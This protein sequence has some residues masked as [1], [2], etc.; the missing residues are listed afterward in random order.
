MRSNL[1]NL[2]DKRLGLSPSNLQTFVTK[3]D[4]IDEGLWQVSPERWYPITG[5][6]PC[7]LPEAVRPD[8]TA[9]FKRHG[10]HAA[11]QKGTATGAAREQALTTVTFSDKWSRFRNYGLDPDHK[12]FL[13]D[14]YCKKLGKGSHEELKA[15]YRGKNLILEVGPGSGFNT[16]FMAENTS[17]T[18]V[19][20]DISEAAFTTYGNT[21][22]LPNC[23]VVQSDL[24]ELP[25]ADETFD[26][27]IADG[28]LHHTPDTRKAVEAL[29][30]K[31]KPGGQF[32]FYVYKKMGAARYFADQFIREHFSK[33]DPE[34]CYK[35]C[36][37]ITEL[38]RE[39]SRLGAK[40]TLTK[41][42][43]ILGIPAGTHDVQRLLYYNFVKC[44]WNE[45]F[46]YETNNMVNFDWYHP[47][48]AWQ[49]SEDEVEGWLK[50]LGVEQFSFQAANPNGIS[51]LLT[52][53]EAAQ[54]RLAG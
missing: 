43:P 18:V 26:F 41:P 30:R 48:L 40:I 49:H 47:H 44:F 37:G 29:Y 5:G 1:I 6:V 33:L 19:A 36:E 31:V 54:R 11:H 53:P 45:A 42:I 12:T 24:M 25:F 39:L 16:R 51:V 27:I 22:D 34:A 4:H 21:S 28:V 7:F 15:F 50:H 2:L 32:F 52:K 9:F 14:W 17:G 3:G 35:A 8:F 13:F 20:A 10:L 38:G 46:D 23:H